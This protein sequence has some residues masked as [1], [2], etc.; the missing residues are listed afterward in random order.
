MSRAALERSAQTLTR[1]AAW[2]AV[3]TSLAALMLLALS[4]RS[5]VVAFGGLFFIISAGALLVPSGTKLLARLL[6]PAAAFGFGIPGALA[7][8]GVSAHL[9][10]TGVAT[11][12]LSVAVATVVGIGLMIGSFRISVEEWLTGTLTADVYLSTE[13]EDAFDYETLEALHT[14]TG[15]LGTNETRFV[16]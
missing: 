11:A 6:E 14:I 12:A 7:A 10:R 15:V 13:S 4:T 5:L 2:I 8:R 9:S 1:R 16:R 3:P